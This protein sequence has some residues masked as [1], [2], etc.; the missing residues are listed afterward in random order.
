[1]EEGKDYTISGLYYR[2][3]KVENK[4]IK[5]YLEHIKLCRVDD[6]GI[7]TIHGYYPISQESLEKIKKNP[8][9]TSL[10]FDAHETG[11]QP[12]TGLTKYKDIVFLVKSTSRFFLK[13]DVGEIFDQIN[14]HDLWD[15][16]FIKAICLN[17]GFDTLPDTEGEHFLMT[18][19]LLVD[20]KDKQEAIDKLHRL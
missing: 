15:Y 20:E 14:Y 17:E 5:E 8:R 19:T 16:K 2:Y 11:E 10:T 3:K 4:D 6:K 1:M 13:P 7:G 9:G 18:A 12:L